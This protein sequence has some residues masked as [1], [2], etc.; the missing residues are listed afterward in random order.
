M[1]QVLSSVL[2]AASDAVS[3]ALDR[4]NGRPAAARG[5]DP[6]AP[7]AALFAALLQAAGVRPAAQPLPVLAGAEAPKTDAP[8]ADTIAAD[9]QTAA[10]GG[11][12]AAGTAAAPVAGAGAGHDADPVHSL[13]AR[14]RLHLA[15]EGGIDAAAAAG[16]AS[17]A[18]AVETNPGRAARG[19]ASVTRVQRDLD[20]LNPEFRARFER[21]VER[22]QAEFGHRVT[23]VEAHR[24]QARQD[25]LYEQGRSRPGPVVTW[26]RNSNHTQGRAADVMIDG[27]YDNAAGY[28]RL[29]QIAAEEGLRTLGPRDPGH[30]ELP[31]GAG[32]GAER[33]AEGGGWAHQHTGRAGA[34]MEPVGPTRAMRLPAGVAVVP[35]PVVATVAAV[36]AVASP[37]ARLARVAV[38]GA[39]PAA[40]APDDLARARPVYAGGA[41]ARPA[42]A[43]AVIAA[44]ETA[45]G[46]GGP[47]ASEA[48]LASLAS[49]ER[50]AS[51]ADRDAVAPPVAAAPPA[52]TETSAERG[53]A[54][55]A[56]AETQLTG[57]RAEAPAAATPVD[58]ASRVAR[59]LELQQSL[60]PQPLRHVTLRVDGPDGSH[61]S[62]RLDLRGQ[63]LQTTIEVGNAAAA[64]RL[65][66]QISQLE[67]ALQRQGLDPEAVQ[68]RSTARPDLAVDAP[69][70]V[71]LAGEAASTGRGTDSNLPRER[72]HQSPE[73][74]ASGSRQQPR[75]EGKGENSRD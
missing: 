37:V 61:D 7:D 68:V 40:G 2:G 5:S 70:A 28:R 69:R 62:I 27:S 24:T 59:V 18:A 9:A 57:G 23:V 11:A 33:V 67:R 60:P 25:H 6:A 65:Q 30:V 21:V 72:G 44:L 55:A 45:L 19:T 39:G 35:T 53:L 10:T 58:V 20:A 13:R 26:T 52:G 32:G 29:A 34:G 49:L 63:A 17:A 73:R 50:P 38:P 48:S 8:E 42:A 12:P 16:S 4:L 47:T 1:M 74:D 15:G 22:M 64:D 14:A 31:R 66:S 56:G 46:V 3:T 41:P 75:R 36:A 51:R 54:A 43:E 71:A